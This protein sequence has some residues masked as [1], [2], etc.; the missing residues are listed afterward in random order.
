MS[1][2][3][4]RLYRH[5]AFIACIPLAAAPVFAAGTEQKL[6]E[7]SVTA[8]REARPT[9]EVPQAISVVGKETLKEKKMFN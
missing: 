8:T 4:L 3:G 9:G 5:H 7:I 2:Q 6:D 1:H